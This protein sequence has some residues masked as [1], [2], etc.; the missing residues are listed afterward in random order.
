MISKENNPIK[1]VSYTVF[2]T[3]KT[4]PTIFGLCRYCGVLGISVDTEVQKS[5]LILKNDVF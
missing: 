5:R 4:L 3:S 1:T 2:S